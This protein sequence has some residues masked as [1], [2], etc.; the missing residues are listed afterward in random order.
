[1]LSSQGFLPTLQSKLS[2]GSVAETGKTFIE[3]AILKARH[4]AKSAN[5]PAIG[6]DSGLMVKALGG[7]PGIYSSRFAGPGASDQEKIS[8]LLLA[9]E[10][11]PE[12]LRQ[13]K[14]QAVVVFLRD[15]DDPA[16]I[17]GQGIWL[18]SITRQPAGVNGFGYDPIFFLPPYGCT[19]AE[20]ATD[21]KNSISHR[22]MA[23]RDLVTKIKESV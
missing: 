3:N 15:A 20:L 12:Q 10:E 17:V 4:A 11:V 13:A 22:A 1:M 18:G 9:M 23:L 19:A 21:L 5:L 7:S 16:P 2:I 8:K 14:F 6:D